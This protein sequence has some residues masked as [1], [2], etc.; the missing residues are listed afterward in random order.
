VPAGRRWCRAAAPVA[1]LQLLQKA[2][3][4]SSRSH[5]GLTRWVRFCDT[6][7]Y[8]RGVSLKWLCVYATKWTGIMRGRSSC[9][10]PMPTAEPGCRRFMYEW[11]HTCHVP[12]VPLKATC[13]NMHPHTQPGVARNV[14]VTVCACKRS[15]QSPP[16]A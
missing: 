9:T 13:T 11:L 2:V 7:L 14:Y 8:L 12:R 15:A 1:Q 3:D 4:G 5:G 10:R 6:D 16:G